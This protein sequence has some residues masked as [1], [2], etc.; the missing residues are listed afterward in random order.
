[1]KTLN[2]TIPDKWYE[3]KRKIKKNYTFSF[4]P[5]LMEKFK[6]TGDKQKVPQ[7]KVLEELIRSFIDG[8]NK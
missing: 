2:F 1:M 8:F 7:G 4:H 5:S 3:V 6:T